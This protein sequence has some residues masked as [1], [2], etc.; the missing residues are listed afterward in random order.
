M[1]SAARLEV[2]G[3][4]L[5]ALSRG[6]VGPGMAG[7]SDHC[8]MIFWFFYLSYCNFGPHAFCNRLFLKRRGL[9]D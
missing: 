9:L 4:Q 6:T 5:S 3:G 8:A 1:L 7:Q 2:H